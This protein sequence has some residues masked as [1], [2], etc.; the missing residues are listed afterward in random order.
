MLWGNTWGRFHLQRRQLTVVWASTPG[1]L[2]CDAAPAPVVYNLGDRWAL[3]FLWETCEWSWGWRSGTEGESP[4]WE[5]DSA[6]TIKPSERCWLLTVRRKHRGHRWAE[7]LTK[8]RIWL[9]C[10]PLR[11]SKHFLCD[12]INFT[13]LLIFALR[14]LGKGYCLSVFNNLEGLTLFDPFQVVTVGLYFLRGG[15]VERWRSR[16]GPRSRRSGVLLGP[17]C[18]GTCVALCWS[19]MSRRLRKLLGTHCLTHFLLVAVLHRG[20]S[21]VSLC[22]WNAARSTNMGGKV[23]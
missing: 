9:T 21:P 8:P 20:Q 15:K 2:L 22:A 5:R 13:D 6:P 12:L 23:W 18:T 17:K 19:V 7:V 14:L 3:A 1:P 10:N 16:P 11:A 4:E